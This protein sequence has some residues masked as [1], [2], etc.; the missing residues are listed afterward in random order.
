MEPGLLVGANVPYRIDREEDHAIPVHGIDRS[1][2]AILLE[3]RND[4]IAAP[5][6]VERWVERLT[7]AL[8]LPIPADESLRTRR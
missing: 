5:A 8:T 2:P 1:Y 7:P 3:I 6:D 4:L